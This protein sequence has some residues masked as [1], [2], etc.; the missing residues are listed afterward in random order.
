MH[1]DTPDDLV[2]DLFTEALWP[3]HP[4]GRP[5]LG[6]VDTIANA[7]PARVK[8]FYHQ[9]Y[10]P[11]N[12]VVA[13]AGNVR[14]DDLVR[15]LEDRMDTGRE[16][17]PGDPRRGTC[18]HRGTAPTAV[19]T[20]PGQ[21]S[22]DRAGP[23]LPRAPTGS[24]APTRI[25]SRSR[26][27]HR[28][29]R[30]HVLAA[31]PGGAR[32]ARAR[33]RGVQLPRRCTRK[34]GCSPPTPARR[35]A[36]RRRSWACSGASSRRSETGRSATTEFERAKGHVKGSLVLSLEDPGG[37]MSGSGKSEIAHGEILTVDQ[38]LRRIAARDASRMRAA[39]PSGYCRSR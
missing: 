23:H 31:V 24:R 17:G 36:G 13:A 30:R 1:E 21:A 33:V 16:L 12:F 34:A 18:G 14:H 10:V 9:H 32:E 2:H 35:P 11:G 22:Q 37:R 4:L 29:R 7:T 38:T 27:E 3:D 20:G 8:R 26:R 5:I 15:M 6:T 25:G 28:A 39:S 19:G